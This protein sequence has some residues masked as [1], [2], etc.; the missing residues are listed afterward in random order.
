VPQT[1]TFQTYS[2]ASH[3]NNVDDNNTN[4]NNIDSSRSPSSPHRNGNGSEKAAPRPSSMAMPHQS[5]MAE[6][7]QDTP[8]ELQPIFAYLSSHANKLY[9]EGYFLKLHDLDSRMKPTA[10]TVSTK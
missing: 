9:Q 2:P 8:P 4:N 10:V 7:S 6:I 1:S 5:I 3:N